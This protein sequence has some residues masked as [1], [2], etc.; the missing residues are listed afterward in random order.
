MN[1][2]FHFRTNLIAAIIIAISISLSVHA[3][4][5]SIM[6][7]DKYVA[8]EMAR[9]RIP[10]VSLAVMKDGKPLLVK[11]YGFADLEDR[12]PVKPETIFQ[13]G[14]VGKQL[15]AAGILLLVQDGKIDLDAKI[16]KYLG[17][18]PSAWKAITVRHLL[19]HTSGL[20]DYPPDMDFRKDY[21]EDDFLNMIKATPLRYPTG[22][23]W[24]YSNYGYVV[25]GIIIHRV[26]GKPFGDYLRERVFLPLGMKTA[27]LIS[28]RDIIPNRADG[29]TTINGEVK[30]HGWVSQSMNS[31]ADGS[32][33]WSML[34][35]IKWN[36]AIDQR[37]LLAPKGWAE[38]WAPAKFNNGRAHPYGFGWEIRRVNG[39][40]LFEH[41]GTWQGFRAF[42]AKYPD[43][44]LTVLLM[45]NLFDMNPA[46][47]AHK[48]AQI[49]D[50]E[51]T[52]KGLPDPTP[53]IS[54]AHKK[55][56]IEVLDRKADRALFDKAIQ[57]PLFDEPDRLFGY[58]RTLG[59]I[60]TFYLSDHVKYSSS[61]VYRYVVEYDAMTIDLEIEVDKKGKIIL[62]E[63]QPG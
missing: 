39:H 25:L 15:T 11:G 23:R 43:D 19:A 1:E 49:V 12:V 10:G 42:I 34:D 24:Q 5:T 7:I 63:L 53:N 31:T 52:P 21:T 6:E 29:Y 60:K 58:L 9:L 33:Y 61:E 14:S 32:Y 44:K 13:T 46:H 41:G 38:M 28:E 22:E 54:A 35:M 26:S 56:V 57:K 51:L 50:P 8:S 55:L 59:P 48:I 3:Q 40:Q 36:E 16:G 37:K 2:F 45:V 62:F 20:G 27:Q 4:G 30:H 18:I 47:M 17:D